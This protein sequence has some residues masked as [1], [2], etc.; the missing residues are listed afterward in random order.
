MVH[1][2]VWSMFYSGDCFISPAVGISVNRLK[3]NLT[4]YGDKTGLSN[5]SSME[6]QAFPVFASSICE[7]QDSTLRISKLTPQV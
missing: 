5:K 7:G 3:A 1:N 2:I 4:F 6:D